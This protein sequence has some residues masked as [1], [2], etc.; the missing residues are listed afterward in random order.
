MT[1]AH[2][3]VRPTTRILVPL[4]FCVCLRVLCCELSCMTLLASSVQPNCYA[5]QRVPEN[6]REQRVSDA[7]AD[8]EHELNVTPD[9]IKSSEDRHIMVN[10]PSV[11]PPS[12][13]L[14]LSVS[15]KPLQ[16]V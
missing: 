15:F 12:I 7:H 3:S 1:G 2:T 13:S 10:N 8:L 6:T 9:F 11:S 14:A 5:M 4:L 16:T